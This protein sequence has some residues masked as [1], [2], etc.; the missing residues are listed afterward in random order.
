MTEEEITVT[1]DEKGEMSVKTRGI[2]GPACIDEVS[3]LLEELAII[4]EVN[5]TDEYHMKAQVQEAVKTK[6]VVRN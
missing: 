2:L 6:Q 1:I 4:T 3:R 5:K